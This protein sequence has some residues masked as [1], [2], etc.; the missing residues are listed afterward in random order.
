MAAVVAVAFAFLIM[1]QIS[2]SP[3]AD[4]ILLLNLKGCDASVLLDST[5]NNKA[6]KDGPPNISL[7]AFYVIDHAKKAVEAACP[8]VVSCADILALAARDAVAL[9]GGPNWEVPKGRKDGRVS[10]ATETRQ[11]PAPTF[12]ISQLQ[13]NFGQ[14]GL[15]MEDLVALSGGHTLG[16]SH[17]SSFQNR[18]HS[19]NATLDVDPTMNPSFAASLRSVCP[20][21][22][23]VKNAGSP[24][25]SSNF[26]FDN[27]YFKLL[28]Q[29]KSIFS[30]D[31][32]LLTNPKTK[33]LVTKFASSQE[34]FE[35]AF[36]KSM[37][38]MSSITG[39]QEI[40]L[41]CR[42]IR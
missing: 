1:F 24:L 30:S 35:K 26:L 42:V 8:A 20:A 17:C 28:L 19:F 39:G 3:T 13:Q 16:F 11:L 23:K 18:I 31:Q 9:S 2:S 7:H 36:V 27:A 41:N 34:A 4:P 22:N 25:D 14:R 15:S 37:I 32:A 5:K 12:N 6:E 21:H 33:A 38:K 29:G 40:R 10:L